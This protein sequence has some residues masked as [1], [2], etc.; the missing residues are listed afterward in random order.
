MSSSND[1]RKRP[2]TSTS[3][4]TRDTVDQNDRQHSSSTGRATPSSSH[5]KPTIIRK[6]SV[7]S[8][9]VFR[10]PDVPAHARTPENRATSSKT[11]VARNYIDSSRRASTLSAGSSTLASSSRSVSSTLQGTP[12]RSQGL[13][14]VKNTRATKT[15]I[16]SD[17]VP[18]GRAYQPQRPRLSAALV[19]SKKTS[20]SK[21]LPTQQNRAIITASPSQSQSQSQPARK[22][23]D[24]NTVTTT[25]SSLSADL[26][27]VKQ[28]KSAGPL[29]QQLDDAFEQ[30]MLAHKRD[31]SGNMVGFTKRASA[32]RRTTVSWGGGDE[33][34]GSRPSGGRGRRGGGGGGGDELVLDVN[35]IG[36]KTAHIAPR[37]RLQVGDEIVVDELSD[38]EEP[39]QERPSDNEDEEEEDEEEERYRPVAKKSFVKSTSGPT[40]GNPFNAARKRRSAV[41]SS[42][43]SESESKSTESNSDNG[44]VESP[45]E[46]EEEVPEEEE[47]EDEEEEDELD[48]DQYNPHPRRDTDGDI[49]MGDA[50]RTIEILPFDEEKM[51]TAPL[52]LPVKREQQ[53]EATLY[54]DDD[55]ED[56]DGEYHPSE[57]LVSAVE[58]LS[59]STSRM[60]ATNQL[61]FLRRNVCVGFLERCRTLNIP[62]Y[63]ENQDSRTRRKMRMQVTYDTAGS[64]VY[65][66]GV[67]EWLCPIC[68]LFHRDESG[69]EKGFNTRE[70]LDCHLAW[71]HEEVYHEWVADVDG[72]DTRE[73]EWKLQIVIPEPAPEPEPQTNPSQSTSATQDDVRPDDSGIF[74]FVTLSPPPSAR[75]SSTARSPSVPAHIEIRPDLKPI[76]RKSAKLQSNTVI[77]PIWA[78]TGSVATKRERVESSVS[79]EV[80]VQDTTSSPSRDSISQSESATLQDSTSASVTRTPETES[81]SPSRSV[82]G[83]S[84][85]RTADPRSSRP[86]EEPRPRSPTSRYPT[87]PPADAP[88][89][90]AARYPYLPMSPSHLG[91]G[92]GP[93]IDESIAAVPSHITGATIT[94]SCRP[95]GPYLFDL[96]GTLPLAEYGVLSWEII[97]R[98]DEIWESDDV[99]DEYK[100]MHALWAR[101]IFVQANRNKFIANYVKGV[102]AFID[103]YWRMI[104]KAAGWSALRFFLFVFLANNFLTSHDVAQVLLYYQNLTGME[105]WV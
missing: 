7:R 29:W 68:D 15:A 30:R 40:R 82:T 21:L 99:K 28:Y 23:A 103:T 85:V 4:H 102:K 1:P 89:G 84:S 46:E 87:P 8:E 18:L 44:D 92:G 81:V 47:E 19:S 98:E 77:K 86:M 41:G 65:K 14:S 101:W 80:D 94:Y 57:A 20:R 22:T 72:N 36:R 53:E 95:G 67:D 70:M 27:T 69:E 61:P 31:R 42:D 71:D 35:D 34:G 37:L 58:A 17:A 45:R 105:H 10:V 11:P 16:P 54:D 32:A 62:I 26:Y 91:D 50:R 5:T 49:V 93:A 48:P 88:L 104:H 25:A 59:L 24:P 43:E 38:D 78:K 64:G 100:V 2:G 6:T 3:D 51:I 13:T 73:Y 9:P 74:P 39:V 63:P 56:S 90:P 52:P 76:A 55:D 75:L 66:A 83:T 12:S 96:L 97:D 33:G 60:R 79:Y